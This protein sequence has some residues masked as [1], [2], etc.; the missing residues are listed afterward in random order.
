METH[1]LFINYHTEVTCLYL[2]CLYLRYGWILIWPL[3]SYLQLACNAHTICDSE[4]RPLGTGLYP[5]IS[6]INHRSVPCFAFASLT[7]DSAKWFWC[8]S[9]LP[10]AVLVFEGRLA[11]VRAVQHIPKGTEVI[12]LFL[13]YIGCFLNKR[14]DNWWKKIHPVHVLLTTLSSCSLAN[15]FFFF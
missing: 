3:L 6:I 14:V 8:C 2:D 5:V 15:I 9:C 12:F 1:I 13:S 7:V 11:V 10:N 4:L